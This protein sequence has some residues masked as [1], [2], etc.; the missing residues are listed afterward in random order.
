MN[1]QR[2]MYPHVDKVAADSALVQCVDRSD[3]VRSFLDSL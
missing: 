1:S 3:D 2:C